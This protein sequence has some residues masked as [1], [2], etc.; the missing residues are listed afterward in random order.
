MKIVLRAFLLILLVGFTSFVAI[1]SLDEETRVSMN[2]AD[3][4][5][6]ADFIKGI[7][8]K[9]KEFQTAAFKFP[10]KKKVLHELNTDGTFT[11]KLTETDQIVWSLI[12]SLAPSK[13]VL[14]SVVSL[15]V[16][17]DPENTEDASVSLADDNDDDW[18]FSLN[19]AAVEDFPTLVPVIIHE[20]S[21]ILSLQNSQ[22]TS[23]LEDESVVE[24]CKN[25]LV[26]EGCL[27]EDSI[28]NIYFQEFWKDSGDYQEEDRTEDE[29][30]DFWADKKDEYVTD[31][32]TTNPVEDFAES[33]TFY[34]TK[35]AV[36]A[37]TIKADKV[38]FF[39]DYPSIVKYRKQVRNEVKSWA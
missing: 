27:N 26:E 35:P 25:Y 23:E 2:A 19:Y 21:H 22:I 7:D 12:S 11:P 8:A 18:S 28:L 24:S 33:I 29:T 15:E 14:D 39:K 13:K 5:S 36:K 16:Y 17:Y 38:N 3:E 32:A 10:K 20:F 37:V 30:I 31:Y 4:L 9:Q 34:V 1:D 6:Q